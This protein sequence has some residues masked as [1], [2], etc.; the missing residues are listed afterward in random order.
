MVALNIK[1][2]LT[3]KRMPQSLARSTEFQLNVDEDEEGGEEGK[4]EGEG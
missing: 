1:G 4:E 3:L 2:L